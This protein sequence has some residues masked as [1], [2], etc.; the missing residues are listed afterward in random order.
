[1]GRLSAPLVG[2]DLFGLK[3]KLYFQGKSHSGTHFG[4]FLTFIFISLVVL[5]FFYFG[6]DLYFRQNP[7]IIYNEQY[8]SWPEKFVLDPEIT[9]I[10]VEINSPY[11]DEFY[12]GRG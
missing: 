1:M 7:T 2:L 8:E 10:L 11:A 9:P 12:T 4:I 6:Q 5:C 3:P